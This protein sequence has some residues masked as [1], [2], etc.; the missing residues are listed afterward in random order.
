MVL[1]DDNFATIVNAVEEGRGIYDNIKKFIQYLLSSNVMEVLV[2]LIAA[3]LQNPPPLVPSQLLWINL[4][5]D[6]SS[7]LPMCFEA[8]PP[9]IMQEKP[10]KPNEALISKH[11]LYYM[12]IISSFMSCGTLGMFYYSFFIEKKQAIIVITNNP[13]TISPKGMAGGKKR[14]KPLTTKL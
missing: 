9:H 3:I 14:V 7:T 4:V 5:T 6:G 12:I 13:S 11:K 1:A 10:I 8:I 2:L